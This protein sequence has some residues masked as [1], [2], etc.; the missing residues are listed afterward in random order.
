MHLIL[1]GVLMAMEPMIFTLG[2]FLIFI[3]FIIII[4]A[5]LLRGLGG[6]GEVKSEGGGVII[7]GPIPIV[8]GSN[9]RMTI[10]AAVLG[11]F[12]TIFAVVIFLILNN[13][14]KIPGM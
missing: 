8:F 14:M 7:I 5:L 3:G 11:V 10:F 9:K 1:F 13:Y 6:E 12:L 2:L 4:F